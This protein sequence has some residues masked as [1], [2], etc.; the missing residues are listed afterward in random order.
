M[1]PTGSEQRIVLVQGLRYYHEGPDHAI[2]RTGKTWNFGLDMRLNART[3]V[4][5]QSKEEPGRQR[6]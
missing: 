2:Q 6:R 3:G 5:G 4:Y 1:R